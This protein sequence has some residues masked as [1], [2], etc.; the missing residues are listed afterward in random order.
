MILILN[1]TEFSLVH[2]NIKKIVSG[3]V[4]LLVWKETKCS[5]E[6]AGRTSLHPHTKPR[7]LRA[8][9]PVNLQQPGV[10]A[11]SSRHHRSPV[12]HIPGIES[13]K[14]GTEGFKGGPQFNPDD[15]ERR[16]TVEKWPMN[17]I[18]SQRWWMH[19]ID[20]HAPSVHSNTISASK[21]TRFNAA[22]Q[23]Q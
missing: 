3:I 4:F 15:E 10:E 2:Y 14:Y 5:C 12:K 20:R 1:Q 22:L 7:P 16:E 21:T 19:D 8:F 17:K 13:F 6:S 9:R 11:G 23:P 18:A